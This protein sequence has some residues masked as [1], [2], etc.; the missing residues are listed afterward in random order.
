[1][2][3]CQKNISHNL[4]INCVCWEKRKSGRG[5]GRG[6]GAGEGAGEGPRRPVLGKREDHFRSL[7]LCPRAVMSGVPEASGERQK[8]HS[9]VSKES[10]R[11]ITY[12]QLFISHTKSVCKL[13]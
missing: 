12:T 6:G 2:L 7:C 1:M 4:S 13:N 8:R 11:K 5:S 3:S 10:F 9:R